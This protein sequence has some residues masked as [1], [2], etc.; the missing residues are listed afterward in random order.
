MRDH[1]EYSGQFLWSGIDYLGEA[2]RQPSIGAGSGLL[3][4]TST[5]KPRGF[6]RESWWSTRPNIHVVRR[7]APTQRSATDP[8]YEAVPTTRYQESLFHGWMLA[9]PAPHTETVEVYT[10]AEE[11]ELFQGGTSLGTQQRHPDASPLVWH[12]PYHPGTL[13]VVAGDRLQTP[14]KPA[15]LNLLP[16]HSWVVPNLPLS[17][18]G[19]STDDLSKFL[20]PEWD[21]VLDVTAALTDSVA[22]PIPDSSTPFTFTLTGPAELVATDSGSNIDHTPFTSP[23]R[24]LFAG[25]VVAILRA[26]APSGTI[27]LKATTPGLP[28]S[29]LTLTALPPAPPPTAQRSF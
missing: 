14:G 1:P 20:T 28:P 10:N 21:D 18:G 17:E 11:A 2:G 7:V 23:T 8:G 9:N 3:D 27:T 5:P 24:N 19:H 6:E 12:V 16:L 15:R 13:T 26:T 29:T 25:T 22:N 4:R